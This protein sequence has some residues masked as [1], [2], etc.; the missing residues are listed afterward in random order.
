MGFT[1]VRKNC[2]PAILAGILVVSTAQHVRAQ[3]ALRLERLAAVPGSGLAALGGVADAAIDV[4]GVIYLIDPSRPGILAVDQRLHHLRTFGRRGSGPGEFREPIAIRALSGNRMG[5]LDRALR[6]LSIYRSVRDSLLVFERA[7]TLGIASESMCGLPDGTF[8]IYGFANGKRIHIF[9]PAG[10]MLRSFGEADRRL[11]PMAG[12][13]MVHGR[14]F[15]DADG[16]E[17]VVTSKFLPVVEMFRISTGLQLWVD[18][19]RPFRPLQLTDEGTSVTI[20]GGPGGNSLIAS[21]LNV[22]AYNIFQ[23]TFDSRMD[24]ATLD[25]VFTYAR[26]TVR[27]RWSLPR[28]DWPLLFQLKKDLA[29]GVE[30]REDLELALYRLRPTQGQR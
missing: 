13:L 9:S 1:S 2:S 4:Q 3:V 11:S 12:D 8:L 16:A 6:R 26:S 10:K 15:C 20:S 18:T 23:T 5:V 28:I 21:I 7:I 19:L 30:V 27:G 25:T 14:V 29:L 22:G 17:V 24:G